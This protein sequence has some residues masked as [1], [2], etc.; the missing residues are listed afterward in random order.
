[1]KK[2]R[3]AIPA[4]APADRKSTLTRSKPAPLALEPRLIFDGD[5]AKGTEHLAAAA[6]DLPADGAHPIDHGAQ[7]ELVEKIVPVLPEAPAAK[8]IVFVDTGVA[9]W[10][11]LVANIKPGAQVILIDPAQDGFSQ[12]Q[13]ALDGVSGVSAI[14][15]I[16]HGAEGSLTLGS[17]SYTAENLTGQDA[18]LCAI[19]QSLTADG[20]I[21]LYG[22][23]VAQ[24]DLGLQ[25]LGL[26]S[27]KTGADVAAS[28]DTTGAA[29]VGG[30]WTLERDTGA[31][32]SERILSEAG[33]VA[34]DNWLNTIPLSGKSGWTAI[35]FGTNRD[36]VGDSQA[37]AAD[38]DIVGDA[39]HGSL[40]T[41][42]ETNGTSGTGDDLLAFRL[43]IDN[44]TSSSNFTGVAIVG[45]DANADGRIDLFISV[46]GRNN[47]QA[48][49][50]LDPGTGANISPSTTS[51]S[52]LPT[53]WLPNNGVYAFNSANYSVVAVSAATDPHWNGNAD[54][55][56]DG[57]TDVFVSWKIPVA[58][59]AAV[60]AKASP[61]DRNGVY[62]PRGSTGVANFTKD[63]VV[64]YVSFTQTQPGPIN[65]DL[66]GVGASYDKNASF[67]SLGVFTA[68]MTSSSPVAA[69]PRVTLSEPISG[70]LLNDAEDNSVS[71]SGTSENLANKSL[72]LSVTDGTHTVNGTTT[73]NGDGTWTVTGLNLSGMDAGTLSVTATADP[74]ADAST[75][76]NVTDTASVIHDATPPAVTIDQLATT[77]AGQPTF[78]GTS[79]LADG[80]LI[81]VTIDADNN[82]LTTNLIYQVLVSGG[83]WA[84]NTA[85]LAPVSGAMPSGGLTGH[86]KVT[87]T[88]TDAAG[89]SASAIALNRP[90]VTTLSTNSLTPTISGTWTN[91]AGDTLTVTVNGATYTIAP[92]GN[93][94]SLNLS[95]STPSSGSLGS[96][97]GGNTYAVTAT[98]T[99]GGANVSDVTTSE[100]T[101]TNSPVVV[102]DI[103]GGAT[104]NGTDTTPVITGTSS[105]SGGFVIVRLDP[106]NDGDLSDAVTYSVT[107]DGSGNWSLDTGVATPIS[108]QR[109]SAGFIGAVG[110]RATDSTGAVSDIQ[111][112]TVTT[113]TVAISSVTSTATTDSSA[114]VNNAGAAANY[115][116]MREDDAVTIAGTATVGTAVDL[117]IRDGSG[118]TLE[119]TGVSVD[120]SG[121]WS[122]TNK[123]LSTLDNGTL[124]IAAT[125]SG[126]AIHAIKSDVVHD[127]APPRIFI[128]TQSIIP[129]NQAVLS[130]A[131]ELANTSLT[132]TVRNSTDT[133]T[134]W[135]GMVT[136]DANGNW[137]VTTPNGTNLIGGNSGT[138]IVR[139]AP[140]ATATDS[141][142]NIAQQAERAAQSV[143][144]GAANTT[145]TIM[146]AAVT[147]DNVI[148]AAEI[149]SGLTLTGT[150]TLTAEPASS[151]SVKVSDGT[152]TVTANVVSNVSGAWTATLTTG[153]VQS[154][155]NGPLT[156][157][158][159][160][161]SGGVTVYDT[162]LPS[163]SLATPALTIS[164]DV[165][166][167]ASGP[168]TFTFTFTE[169]VTGFT[170]GDIT[171]ANGTKGAFSG[172]GTTYTLVVTP[173]SSSSGDITVSVASG[174]ANGV[175]TGRA[176]GADTT[177]QAFNTTGA[178]AAPTITIDTSALATDTAPAITGASSLSAGAPIVIAIDTDNDGDT[179]LAYSATVQ[180]DG[181]WT[182][183]LGT[184][185]PTSGSLP[186][187][188]LLPSAKITATATNAYGNSASAIGLN[189]PAV[190][191]QNTNDSTPTITGAW[192]QVAG[193]T[194]AV[195][196]NGVTYSVA[197][198]NLNVTATGW[199]LTPSVALADN[200][201]NVTASVTRSG[202]GNATDLTSSEVSIDTLASVAISGGATTDIAG[203]STPV[204]S[205]TSTGLPTGTVLTLSLDTD[206]DGNVDL[207]YKTTVA[208]NGSWSI[209]TA[210]ATPA[211]GTFPASGLTGPVG[212]TAAATDPSGNVGTDTQTLTVDLIGPIIALTFSA[213]TS[214]TTPVITGTTDLPPGGTITVEIDPNDDGN[215]SD[216]H[217]YTATVQSDGTWAVE[218]T[219]TLSG[220]VGVRA[221]GT[222]AVG[223]ATTTGT[224]PLQIVL[225][226]P[227]ID[228]TSPIPTVGVDNIADSTEDDSV[229]L[230]GVTTN[231]TAGSTI[232]VTISDGTITITDI[233]V[234][235]NDGSW[236][237]AA[238]NLSALANGGISVSATVVDSDSSAYTGST[239][240]A[241]DKS[242]TVAIDS[243]SEDTGVLSDFVTR[244]STV[245]IYGTATANASVAITV[246]DG[247]NATI[248]SFNVNASNTGAWSTSATSALAAGSYTISATVGGTTVTRALTIVDAAAPTLASST[249]V[250]NAT[251]VVVG[252]NLALTFSKNIQAGIGFVSLYRGDGT[253]IENFNVATG[254]GD[255]GGTLAFSGATEVSLNPF[256]DLTAGTGYYLKIDA[257]AVTDSV[258]N[259]YA[260]ISNAA[261]LNFTAQGA[262]DVTP[263]VIAGPSGNAGDASSAKTINE[264]TAAVATFTADETVTWSL[265]GGTD[266]S[267]FTINAST[268]ALTFDTA[269]D[270]EAPADADTNNTYIVQLRAVDTNGNASTQTIT[271][272][273]ANVD[274]VSPTIT[275]PS[276]NAG[277]AASGKTINENIS[278]VASF[279]AN[280]SV[281]WSLVGG[282]DQ[283]KFT[284]NASTGALAFNAA[285]DYETPTGSNTNNT[286]EVQVRAVDANG[287]ASVQTLTVTIA[288]VDELAPSITGPSGN[289]GDASCAKTINE[290]TTAVATFTANESVTW[291]LLGGADQAKFTINATTG[292]LSFNS[293]PDFDSPA[294]ADANNTY[295]VHIRAVDGNGNAS[296]QTVTVTVADL[297][298]IA[299]T[300][301]GPSGNAGDATAAKTINEGVTAV[302]TLA[303]NEAVT[304]S[305]VGGAD[306]SRFTINATTGALSFNSAADFE[307]PTD[308]DTNNTYVV[309]VRAVDAAGNASIQTLTI[310][311]ADMDEVAPTITGPSGG[312]GAASSARTINEGVTAITTFTANEAV[313]WSIVGGADQS[314]FTINATTGALSLSSAPDYETPTDSGANNTYVVQVRA[315]DGSGNASTQTLTVTIADI[316][317][318]AP[319][320]TGPS[321]GAGSL[322]S[323]TTI[324]EGVTAVTTF[325]ANESVT[326]SLIGGSDQSQFSINATTGALNFSFGPDYEAPTDAD[327]NNT[328]V[329]QV[330][331]VDDN[332]NV[333][334]QTLTVTVA[335]V[336][337]APVAS[338]LTP[339]SGTV[340][341][342]LSSVQ[343]PAF[344]DA[345]GT[346]LTYSAAMADGSN[347]P[348]WL[349]FNSTTRTF[350]GTP[351]TGTSAGILNLRVTASDGALTASAVTTLT[352][353]LPG[354][355]TSGA[356]TGT[357]I[358]A[359]GVDN[360]VPGANP[361]GNVLTNDQGVALRVSHVQ[362]G[363]TLSSPATVN[364]SG[365]ATVTG[366]Y[367]VLTISADG[368]YTYAV[369]NNNAQVEALN[370]GQALTEI[371]TYRV[372]DQAGQTSQ[373]TLTLTVQG[374]TDEVPPVP[375]QP[376]TPTTPPS[377]PNIVVAAP[378][379]TVSTPPPA[380]VISVQIIP[381]E[382]D[383][384]GVG[385]SLLAGDSTPAGGA[386]VRE[387]MFQPTVI[388]AD[389][390]RLSLYRGVP[391]Q[392]SEP[393]SVF[394]FT[395]PNDAFAHSRSD[396]QVILHAALMDG[397][398]LPSWL[399]FDRMTGT[400]NGVPPKDFI[401]E[402]KIKVIARD[403]QGL[404]AEAIFRFN[405]GAPKTPQARTG[406]SQ[407]IRSLAYM[408]PRGAGIGVAA[409]AK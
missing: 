406:F 204:I 45:L 281:T 89:N 390:A 239:T 392:F 326:W 182:L 232:T 304:W 240:F 191:A 201:Y 137:S 365:F 283:A 160:V 219:A 369:D 184:A 297:D 91:I 25:F 405:V 319:A 380:P 186:T 293:A 100:I 74:D 306:Q 257:T 56:N 288:D 174:V 376:Q 354:G 30:D 277:D 207:T 62:G 269:P 192:A 114:Q 52:P 35:M 142:G 11:T 237:L 225:N 27:E 116:N 94:W 331:A 318:A 408:T 20:D 280:E 124:T 144:Q 231:I 44:P 19:G 316:D 294:D 165:P 309:Q 130:G 366:A 5:V 333:S 250:D 162:E 141:A 7:S 251:G 310:A 110:I 196:V 397:S 37:G 82:A 312:A 259:A 81:T 371:L 173:T 169:P 194:V 291:S 222:D 163:L 341:S 193:D 113:P 211:S 1:M 346:P 384:S 356:D 272:T 234:V 205:G 321:G 76:N 105:N 307:T 202:G 108:G 111:V 28:D 398:A 213:K 268:G 403:S 147:G 99:R 322:T 407:Q 199:S 357:A 9:D 249:P 104:V 387:V 3:P 72:N 102:I 107:P 329:V 228:I 88:A 285:P 338:V 215:W 300:I 385:R 154:L 60:L 330:R 375:Q 289:P 65:G 347:L 271:V 175:N 253:L 71:I 216:K 399:H 177:T 195:V 227:T 235:Q 409:L 126:T 50:L 396:S 59:L 77:T 370:A 325:T 388:P 189:T 214:D 254:I 197:N 377:T 178:A 12:I 229:V 200:T 188:G 261:T 78:T 10:Q 217:T 190:T 348:T 223:N 382:T 21:L 258:G 101:I 218:A 295:L 276:G 266:Q 226:A 185:T 128:N 134:V 308:A 96:F 296:T 311:I 314:R 342:S 168:V 32:E 389:T 233:A 264:N 303:T 267:K 243:I 157:T 145:N 23:D 336:N 183:N 69:G 383:S 22:C 401:G 292:A 246:K 106:N 358:E 343:M 38:T 43:R 164:D 103:T 167:T 112:L 2:P 109:P 179:D 85:T 51:T 176:N 313:T 15:I 386:V 210:I 274:E 152:T 367:G 34:Y 263:P 151:F 155:R 79:D 148:T 150:T 260:G 252:S 66:N 133:T 122:V 123:D 323:A 299:P 344:T 24:G 394:H 166:G 248:D 278:T 187:E 351:P 6:F 36:P 352:L 208:A 26:L 241:H 345:D 301:T 158:A 334:T 42:Y 16:S 33:V 93:T 14:H 209:D 159:E 97:A 275:G 391:D 172:S 353:S 220:T 53:G 115:L 245:A 54:I 39:S 221:F 117:V 4:A 287:N 143:Q 41:A 64:S 373:A 73:V 381:A 378:S 244:D 340:G 149:T 161:T 49:R 224:K 328:Y 327:T 279:T 83:T 80:S 286:Y 402:L 92:S 273:I 361:V 140:T 132:I 120:G 180:G 298:E 324:N 95:S 55:G 139:V 290:G 86:T 84:L 170:A 129:K 90:T 364:P 236:S 119:Y 87:A 320:I 131:S 31:I 206:N 238:L 379:V 70:G 242:A 262:G 302:T 46:D 40:Y 125:L 61:V 270:F 284:I 198:G 317:E 75:L 47:T 17:T 8:E 359:A 363:T 400:F 349:T 337:E 355:P 18:A 203:D 153:Q 335:N 282:T 13:S 368:S 63:T 181:T 48:V 67:S 360:A 362:T 255:Q 29:A 256:A 332:G 339:L 350:S 58:D 395:I 404:Q 118:N 57:K 374:A 127:A 315:V 68:P 121:N 372:T 230:A 212:L 305:L 265:I 156:V 393:N 136:T 247:S 138:V 98:V 135:T 171:V 146:I